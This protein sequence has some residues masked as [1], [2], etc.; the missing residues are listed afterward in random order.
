MLFYVFLVE[1]TDQNFMD[2]E[3][4]SSCMPMVKRLR[5]ATADG[6]SSDQ[7]ARNYSL[8]DKNLK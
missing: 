7:V 4:R 5:T 1:V 6:S 3:A 2:E 8:S